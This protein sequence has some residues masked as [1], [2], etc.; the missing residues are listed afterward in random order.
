[1]YA[2]S[3]ESAETLKVRLGD[4]STHGLRLLYSFQESVYMGSLSK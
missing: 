2:D 4:Q 1:M 3:S